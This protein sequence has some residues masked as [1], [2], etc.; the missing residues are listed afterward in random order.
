MVN[1]ADSHFFSCCPGDYYRTVYAIKNRFSVAP[2]IKLGN[3]YYAAIYELENDDIYSSG[4][5]YDW[6]MMVFD[7]GGPSVRT[8][9]GLK[10]VFIQAEY[11]MT[12]SLDRVWLYPDWKTS[13]KMGVNHAIGF[14]L[15]F[16][17]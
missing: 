7:I 9:F 1:A 10:R 6:W 13:G 11:N 8:Q 16:L 12:F 15:A 2:G 14:D 5:S 17:L 4:S 3:R